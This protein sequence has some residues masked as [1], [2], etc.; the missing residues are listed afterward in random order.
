MCNE[1]ADIPEMGFPGFSTFGA[2]GHMALP[3]NYVMDRLGRSQ[4]DWRYCLALDLLFL[5]PLG[6]PNGL[7]FSTD[8]AS[9]FDFPGGPFDSKIRFWLLG[10]T[11]NWASSRFSSSASVKAARKSS[12]RLF[13]C[14]CL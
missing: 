12:G 4:R 3:L 8:C 13:P 7:K 6:F 14:A 9:F 11:Y 10:K 2:I 1:F 5:R